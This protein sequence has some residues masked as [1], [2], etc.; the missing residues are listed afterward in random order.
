VIAYK[1]ES[2]T[3]LAIGDPL[4]PPEEIPH[5]LAAF[6]AHCRE[7][8]WAFAF[9]QAR[10]ERLQDYRAMG[11]RS[12]HIGEDPMLW[13]ERFTLEGSALGTVRRAVGKLER[14]G[15]EVRE[16]P[17]GETGFD[18]GHD[19]DGLLDQMRAISASWLREHP[20]GEKGFCMG[21]FDPGHLRDAWLVVAWDPGRR[22]VEGFVTWTPIP[23]RRGWALDLMRRRSDAPTGTMEYLRRRTALVVALGPGQGG[24]PRRARGAGGAAGAARRRAFPPRGGACARVPDG[25]AGPLLRLQGAVPVEAQVRAGVRGPLPRV[26]RPARP[27]AGGAGPAAGAEPGRAAVVPPAPFVGDPAPSGTGVSGT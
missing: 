9:Y 25:E 3:L 5:L 7:H 17:P 13:L 21:R 2:G 22:R 23:A 18:P 12:V 14:A 16:F 4:G 20:G 10:P 1:F 24:R 6:A 8:D 15:L 27:A 19:P 26:P 11:W